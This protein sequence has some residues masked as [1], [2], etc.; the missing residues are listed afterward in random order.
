MSK[1][2]A[3]AKIDLF[4]AICHDRHIDV[5]VRVFSDLEKAVEYCKGFVPPDKELEDQ[6]L[7][8]RMIRAGWLYYATYGTEGDS[9]RVEKGELY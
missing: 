1:E 2:N 9:V 8:A 4:I 6:E 5:T 7:T 3:I